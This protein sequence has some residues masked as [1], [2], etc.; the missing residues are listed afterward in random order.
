MTL[1]IALQTYTV[2]EQL[3]RDFEG[4]I[5]RVAA[6]G[7]RALE[8]TFEIPGTTWNKAAS[9]FRE[10]DLRVPAAHTPL[11][12][13]KNQ[14]PVLDY[15]RQMG[16]SYLVAG[17]GPNDFKRID[18]IRHICDQYNEAAAVAAQHGLALAYH[19]HWWEFQTVEGRLAFDVMLE[20]LD[21]T[22]GFEIDTYWVQTAGHDPAAVVQ[23][24]GERAP[25]LHIKDGPATVED[26]MVAVGQGVLD[27]HAIV[28]AAGGAQWLI[29]ELDRCATDMLIAVEQSHRYLVQEGLGHA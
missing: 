7:Y 8:T 16:L 11:P 19:N 18:Q 15:A 9:L 17:H 6:M 26:S 10:L 21:P 28:A 29:V 23:R 3:S 12:L 27:F 20:H 14:E 22:V 24:L 13:G 5:R 2:R 25:L 4:T 1:P